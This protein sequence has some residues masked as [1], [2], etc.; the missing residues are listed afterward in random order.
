MESN[1]LLHFWMIAFVITGEIMCPVELSELQICDIKAVT[2]PLAYVL[3]C[4]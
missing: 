4:H 1:R 3:I 2:E